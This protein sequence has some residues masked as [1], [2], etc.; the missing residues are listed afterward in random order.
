MSGDNPLSDDVACVAPFLDLLGIATTQDQQG[1]IIGKMT[2]QPHLIGNPNVPALHGGGVSSLLET[3][4]VM[5]VMAATDASDIP[6][7]INITVDFLRPAKP[8]DTYASAVLLRV[9]RRIATVEATAWQESEDK[10]V[11]SARVL[12]RLR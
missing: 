2:Y 12:L 5:Q 3:V 9:G 8:L 11:T 6:K 1:H 7:T 4:A 10:P